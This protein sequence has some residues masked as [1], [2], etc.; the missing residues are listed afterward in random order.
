MSL[1][2]AHSLNQ[3]FQTLSDIEILRELAKLYVNK[4][5]FTTSFGIEDQIIAHLIFSHRIGIKV[6]TIDTG[7][8]FKET[9][10]TYVQTIEKYG[11]RIVCY[12]PDRD[13]VEKL[14]TEKGPQSF[15]DS[16]ENRR[17]CCNIRKVRPLNRLLQGMDC[18]VTGIRAD[19]SE[20]RT[21]MQ[22]FIWDE[23]NLILKYNPLLRWTFEECKDFVN[24]HDIPYNPLHDK[25]FVSIGCEP[26]TRA[27]MPGEDFRA[28]RWW[29]E[30]KSKKECGLHGQ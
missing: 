8:L 15:Y 19:Q 28:G 10:K 29:W 7:R 16:I 24:K 30:D 13:D 22:L 11:E 26:C 4:I 12:F 3:R 20:N 21:S 27:I 6:A 1:E 17:E 2:L 23:K 14:V 5:V 25:G 9:Y 18:W